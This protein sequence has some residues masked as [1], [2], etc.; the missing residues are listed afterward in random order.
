MRLVNKSFASRILASLPMTQTLSIGHDGADARCQGPDV[1]GRRCQQ[2]V[3]ALLGNGISGPREIAGHGPWPP[4]G[5]GVRGDV[6]AAQ[7][8]DDVFRHFPVRHVEGFQII[9][10]GIVGLDA[11]AEIGSR[12]EQKT[13][14]PLS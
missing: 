9:C 5:D 4:A 11:G 6:D 13:M 7:G 1:G 3:P 14:S 8:P 12:Y 10:Q 2:L